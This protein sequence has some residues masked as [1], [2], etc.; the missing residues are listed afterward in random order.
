[1][2]TLGNVL[3]I[4]DELAPIELAE[5][6]DN[7]G[8]LIGS[9]NDSVSKIMCALDL[10]EDIADEAINLGVDCIVTPHFILNNLVT[11]YYG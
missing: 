11:F 6:W 10:N 9:K 8:I 5:E 2:Y 4:L 3:K 7:V 1:M